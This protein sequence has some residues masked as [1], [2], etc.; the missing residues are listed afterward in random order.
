MECA[1]KPAGYFQIDLA[2]H[3][4]GNSSGEFCCTL[5]MTDVKT[6]RTVHFALRNKAAVW[7]TKALETASKLLPMGLKGIH[8]DTGSEFI[9]KP[10]G[11][12]RQRNHAGFT[13]G[14]PAHKNDNCYVERKNY[15]AVR[16]VAGCFRYQGESGA[17][18]LQAVYDACDP[19]LRH[20]LPVYETEW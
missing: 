14:R 4:G 16:R 5:T 11:R 15:A 9:N 6:G 20:V 3:D 19:L 1:K 18:A 8:S 7:V 17:A 10:A 12:W 2:R 13:R